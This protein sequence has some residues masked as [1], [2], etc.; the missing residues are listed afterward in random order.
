MR[1]IKGQAFLL[2]CLPDPPLP[3]EDEDAVLLERQ[4]RVREPFDLHQQFDRWR[5]K[6]T[7]FAADQLKPGHSW[8]CVRHEFVNALES[9]KLIEALDTPR[10]HAFYLDP[11]TG[12]VEVAQSGY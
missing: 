3:L 11:R 5:A 9:R 6:S 4:Y 2:V 7:H 8:E 1:L 10:V 12:P